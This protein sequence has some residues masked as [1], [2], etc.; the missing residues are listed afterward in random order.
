MNLFSIQTIILV[1][2]I[3]FISKSN[4]TLLESNKN[5]HL[6]SSIDVHRQEKRFLNPR[7]SSTPNIEQLRQFG[8]FLREQRIKVEQDEK[9]RARI[10]RERLVNRV[11]NSFLRDMHPLRF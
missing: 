4:S 1:F 7:F 5:V 2:L 11:P 6:S 9:K 10:Y 3:A 8:K